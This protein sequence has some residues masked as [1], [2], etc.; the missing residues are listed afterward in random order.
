LSSETKKET[1]TD[2]RQRLFSC[3][4]Y[5]Y[6]APQFWSLGT[7]ISHMIVSFLFPFGWFLSL[8]WFNDSLGLRVP[9]CKQASCD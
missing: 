4:S 2:D 7:Y 9:S 8:E 1:R 3:C 5:M 6:I